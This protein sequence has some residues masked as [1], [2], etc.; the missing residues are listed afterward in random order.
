MDKP[1]HQTHQ[2]KPTHQKSI[3]KQQVL[4]TFELQVFTI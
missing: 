2:K 4:Y 1:T 3:I